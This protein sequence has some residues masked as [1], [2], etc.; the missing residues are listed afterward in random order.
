MDFFLKSHLSAFL[1]QVADL[2]ELDVE[3]YRM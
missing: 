1:Q 2:T 3:A